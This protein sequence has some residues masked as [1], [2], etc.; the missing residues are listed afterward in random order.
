M[1]VGLVYSWFRDGLVVAWAG[2]GWVLPGFELDIG[3][4]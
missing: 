3:L 1:G 4:A 2:F